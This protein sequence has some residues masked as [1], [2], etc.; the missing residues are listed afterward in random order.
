MFAE[1]LEKSMKKNRLSL[2]EV[3]LRQGVIYFDGSNKGT[4]VWNTFYLDSNGRRF[5]KRGIG[6]S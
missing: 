4:G 6:D 3:R 1:T 5:Y 2:E